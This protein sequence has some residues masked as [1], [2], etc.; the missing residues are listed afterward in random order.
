MALNQVDISMMEDIPA[1]GPAGKIIISDGTGWT[2]G[3][4]APVG[5]I[6][7]QATDPTPSDPATPA[8]G[9]LILNNTTG[10]LFCCTT[11][12]VGENIWKNA[13]KGTD[14][15]VPNDPPTNPT[16]TGDF[17]STIGH[18]QTIT[19][20]FAGATDPDA[21]GSVTH[22]IVDNIDVA[23]GGANTS[24][25]NVS[26]AEVAAGTDHSFVVGTVASNNTVSFRVRAKDDYGEY[27]TG[28]TINATIEP[29]ISC[30]YLVIGGGGGGEDIA[31]GGGGA[32]G[33]SEGTVGLSSGTTYTIKVAAGGPRHQRGGESQVTGAALSAN[34]A[35]S[36]GAVCDNLGGGVAG[37][38]FD[39]NAATSIGFTGSGGSFTYRWI[40]GDIQTAQKIQKYT[41]KCFDAGTVDHAWIRWSFEGSNNTTD[42]SDGD[43]VGLH[44]PPLNQTNWSL[45]EVR[46]FWFENDVAY[47]YYRWSRIESQNTASYS[48]NM[49]D[50][51]LF[52]KTTGVIIN[53]LGGGGAAGDSTIYGSSG[54]RTYWGYSTRDGGS[55]AGSNGYAGGSSA[56]DTGTKGR[57]YTG[58]GQHGGDGGISGQV[59]SGNG[60]G[61][62]GGGGGANETGYPGNNVG[63]GGDGGDGKSS[64]I[65]GS[66]VTRAGGGG[67]GGWG[68]SS[69]CHG[70]TGGVGGAGNGSAGAGDAAAGGNGNVNTGSG[71]GGHGRG[72]TA[73]NNHAGAGGSGVVYLKVLTSEYNSGGVTGGTGTPTGLYTCIEWTGDGSYIA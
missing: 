59:L 30:E 26:T 48:P 18:D 28:V 6:T 47:R 13:G 70:G 62:G 50:A 40:M 43:W 37:N 27:S 36:T 64:S 41:L 3:E 8:I 20:Q 67:A 56:L 58:Q 57:A 45:G 38:F 71:G 72:T 31:G 23:S 61:G 68:G 14:D 42:G 15:V 69:P 49:A 19:F 17:L 33:Y 51:Q 66:P 63:A 55:G 73:N 44:V 29:T 1:P 60:K 5:N 25:F 39:G 53:G 54:D 22:Y 9:D 21:G 16:N 46:T 11:V 52:F 34:Q 10:E 32:G 12:A 24:V 7:K 35:T 65:T 2:S 4:N